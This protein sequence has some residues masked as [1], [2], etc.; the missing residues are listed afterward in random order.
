MAEEAIVQGVRMLAS[1]G[2]PGAD[3]R[4][5]VTKDAFGGGCVQPF[6]QRSKNPGDL[7]G[8][9]FQTVQGRVA[10]RAERGAA[11]LTA[12]R[13]D[14]FGMA[15]LAIANERMNVCIGDAAG[16]ALLIGTGEAF[17]VDSLGRVSATF[18]LAPGTYREGHRSYNRRVGARESGNTSA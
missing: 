13:L 17:G 15:M 2:Q 18:D 5:S 7:L 12:E 14:P 3:G 16:C 1:S 6:G 4:L 11:S 9:G 10:S 8:R